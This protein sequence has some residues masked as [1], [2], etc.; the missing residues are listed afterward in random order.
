MSQQNARI[1][2]K[3]IFALIGPS[4]T[5]DSAIIDLFGQDGGTN[6]YSC[7]A[8]YDVQS[9]TAKTFDSGEAEVDTAT[10]DTKAN[11][12]AGDYLVIY[13]TAG[14]AWAVAANISGTDPAPTGAIWVAIPAARKAQ[15]NLS[16]TTTA[17]TVA[18]AFQNAFNALTAV[19]FVAND[20]TADCA[21]TQ[22]IRG[23]VTAPSVHNT[24]DTGAGSI[25][26]VVTNAGVAS[27]VD[28][29]AN[30]LTIPAHGYA[31]GLKG[32]LTTTG[33]LPGGLA[34]STD[35]FVISV[36]VNT[37]KLATS[38]VNAV[39]GTAI[40]ITNQGTDGAVNTFTAT[41]LAGAT[42]TFRE[43]NDR[44]NWTDVQTATSI[45]TDGSVVLKVANASVRYF[46]AV[47]AL[48]AGQV[49]LKANL[50]VIGDAS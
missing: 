9:P 40:N 7:Q 36:D 33:T 14:L 46:K 43:S 34:V 37:I 15:V 12:G 28:V 20:S 21:F 47:K 45:S 2:E 18:T 35:Y 42:V 19:P 17:A 26:V 24:G 41:A 39:A 48:T 25:V 31:T 30:T 1:I 5:G 11:T 49:D 32:Q 50:L 23:P 3:D 8:V 13:D 44:V 6:R 16:A 4:E 38:L 27:E 22:N 10:F 29:D